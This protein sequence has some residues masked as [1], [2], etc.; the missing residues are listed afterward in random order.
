MPASSADRSALDRYIAGLKT[1]NVEQIATTVADSLRFVTA[2]ATL[3]K[4]QFLTMLRALYAAFPDWHYDHDAPEWLGDAVAIKW[5]QG[6]THLGTWTLSGMPPVPATGKP[7]KILEQFFFY[8]LQGGQIV[9]IC[10][11]PV[12]GGAPAG[13]LEQIGVSRPPL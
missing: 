7:V 8:Q 11:D 13:I 3:N 10:P 12:P 1:R 9:E 4:E 6:G 5:R 2:T